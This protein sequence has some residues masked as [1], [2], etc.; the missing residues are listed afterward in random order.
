MGTNEQDRVSGIMGK[1]EGSKPSGKRMRFDPGSG[2]IQEYTPDQPD[3]GAID[4]T[5][6]TAVTFGQ[7]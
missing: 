2:S 7:A 6:A 3:D 4:V 1:P 5:K